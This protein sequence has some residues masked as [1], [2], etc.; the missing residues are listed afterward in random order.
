MNPNF[1]KEFQSGKTKPPADLGEAEIHPGLNSLQ[2]Y[3]KMDLEH[4]R[5]AATAT[6]KVSADQASLAHLGLL[7]RQLGICFRLLSGLLFFVS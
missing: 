4:P 2:L 6:L 3:I 7:E 1:K 5:V